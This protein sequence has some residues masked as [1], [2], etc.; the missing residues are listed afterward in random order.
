MAQARQAFG[1][2]DYGTA[3]SDFRD[4]VSRYGD[5]P[6]GPEA[7][8]YLGKIL[9]G[10]QAYGDAASLDLNVVRQWPDTSWAPDAALDLAKAMVGMHEAREACSVLAQID[11]HYPKAGAAVRA[12]EAD[13]RGQ[14]SCPAG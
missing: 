9:L 2:G 13:V 14:A 3:E 11:S 10:R 6:R 8:Y 4:I 12:G 1:A 5:T 7:R